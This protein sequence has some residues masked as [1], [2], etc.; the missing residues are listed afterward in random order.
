M[1]TEIN[2]LIKDH[3]SDNFHAQNVVNDNS[4]NHFH[5][6]LRK[7]LVDAI[8]KLKDGK[9]EDSGLYSN[10]LKFASNKFN[11]LLT[12][13]FNAML[14]HG[15]APDD[16]LLGTMF[17]LIKDSRG[18]V[19]SSDNYRAITIGTCISKLF[20]LIILNKQAYAFQTGDLQFGFKESSSPVICSFVAQEVI[21]HYTRNDSDVYTVLLDA[22]KAFDRVNFIKLFKK[23]IEKK[24]CPLVLRLLLNSYINQKLNVRWNVTLSETFGV[25]NGVR[26]GGILSPILFGV[27]MD[28]LLN[29]L[30]RSGI[31]CHI[32]VHYIGVL[33][34][35]DDIILLCPTLSGMRTMLNIC[36]KFADE[37]N[38]IFNGNKSKLLIFSKNNRNI[39]DPCFKLNGDTIKRFNNAIHLG[40]VLHTDNEHDCIDEGIKSFNRSVNMFIFRFKLCSPG[41]R[42]KLFQQYCM[43]L[44]GSQL[45]PLWHRS[46]GDL[47]TKWNIAVRRILCLPSRTHR[48]LLPLIVEQMPVE[49]S[50]HCRLIKFYRNL[51]KS[52]NLIVKY[53][54]NYAVSSAF[55][56]LGTNI[57][58]VSNRLNISP[59]EILSF[60]EEKLKGMCFSKWSDTVS[61]VN[62]AHASVIREM[63][64]HRELDSSNFFDR[65]FCDNIIQYLSTG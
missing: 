3:C 60:S 31:G 53:I 61:D 49:V 19:H 48:E 42:I 16:L 13:F 46:I 35:A 63:I 21:N 14:R 51:N 12:M 32:G 56:T 1:K 36:E 47:S 41:I 27:Y 20:E 44:Y 33:G 40:N 6:L 59:N 38:L 15:V 39:S 25:S 18:K 28:E 55:S 62:K 8:D 50:L 23:L 30:K 4:Q 45:W 57:R 24:M 34:F 29:R 11:T 52:N 37:Y 10:H 58:L 5:L 43:A 54:A 9:K 65:A 64:D 26:Q 7:D 22:S 2:D 17:P